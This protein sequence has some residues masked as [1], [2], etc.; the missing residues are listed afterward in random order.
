MLFSEPPTY[1]EV[2][3]SS[4]APHCSV[5]SLQTFPIPSPLIHF[6]AFLAAFNMKSHREQPSLWW[7]KGGLDLRRTPHT[8]TP[9]PPF[10]AALGWPLGWL[11]PTAEEACQTR[12]YW[13]V[14]GAKGTASTDRD[15][16]SLCAQN[17][18]KNTQLTQTRT[19]QAKKDQ[20]KRKD[21]TR[22]CPN[23]GLVA[24]NLLLL[25]WAGSMFKNQNRRGRERSSRPRRPH[26]GTRKARKSAWESESEGRAGC[27]N[28]KLSLCQG[29]WK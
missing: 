3:S 2:F 26:E 9:A 17:W 22:K 4:P 18:T 7:R 29:R 12:K 21:Q 13:S 15:L 16:W 20:A 10:W 19:L 5:L 23:F 27:W 25:T 1:R 8:L 6:K 28:V 14:T 11:V 24:L